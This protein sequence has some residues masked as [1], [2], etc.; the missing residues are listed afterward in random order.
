[1][2]NVVKKEL[3]KRHESPRSRRN[4]LNQLAHV[5]QPQGHPKAKSYGGTQQINLSSHDNTFFASDG[6]P[7]PMRIGTQM[8]K[9]T[10]AQK[11]FR[12]KKHSGGNHRQQSSDFAANLFNR[13]GPIKIPA[14]HNQTYELHGNFSNEDM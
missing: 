14:T 7:M 12:S 8:V 9:A 3:L 13:T 4:F 6:Q 5:N 11:N 1:V 10:N 2:A